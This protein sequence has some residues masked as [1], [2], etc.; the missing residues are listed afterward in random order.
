MTG[1]SSNFRCQA[2]RRWTASAIV[3]A[4]AVPLT[5]AMAP[6]RA[7][8]GGASSRAP[9]AVL[10]PPVPVKIVP[11]KWHPVPKPPA[12]HR[13]AVHWPG[14][15]TAVVTAPGTARVAASARLSNAALASP[16]PGAVRAGRLPVWLGAVAGRSAQVSV[17]L[18][19]IPAARA[20]GINGLIFTLADVGA[21]EGSRVRVSLDY[22]RFAYAYLGGWASML[23]LVEMPAC[24]LTTP[25]RPACRKQV[26]LRSGNDVQTRHLGGIVTLPGG[27]ANV[28]LAATGTFSSSSGDY[29]AT[30]LGSSGNW[31]EGGPSGAFTYSYPI[32]VPPAPGNL[33]PTVDLSYSSQAVDGLTSATNNQAS[34]IGDG[35]DYSPGFIQRNYAP[36]RQTGGPSTDDLCYSSSNVTTMS[37][38]GSS[39]TLVW[40]GSPGQWKAEAD[41][42]A[43]VTYMSSGT[44]NGTT[45]GD[46]WVVKEPD[47]TT[48]YF[49]RQLPGFAAGDVSADA[50]WTVPVYG[51]GGG[52]ARTDLTTSQCAWRWMLDY[53]V[54]PHGN[55]MAYL[56]RTETNW[57]GGDNATT[58]NVSYTQ[59]GSLFE[60]WYGLT[61]SANIYG[62]TDPSGLATNMV[63][64]GSAEVAFTSKTDRTDIDSSLACASG[65]AS[66]QSAPTFWAKYRLAQIDTWANNG[67]GSG[68]TMKHVDSWALA[69][70]YET[71][72]GTSM[73]NE[74]LWLSSITP[75][76]EDLTAGATITASLPPVSF[77][78]TKTAL[79]NLALNQSQSA[80]GFDVIGRD[81]ISLVTTMTG[82]QI[83]VTYANPTGGCVSGTLPKLDSNTLSCYPVLFGTQTQASTPYWFN[84][85]AVSSVTQS[86]VTGGA[87][88]ITTS[89][90]YGPAAWHYDDDAITK[91]SYRTWDQFR[92]F[93]SVTTKT[94]TAPDPVTKVTDY[95]FQ[96]MDGDHLTGGTT[97]S[98]TLTSVAD[99]GAIT[100]TDKNQWAGTLFEQ[101]I[102]N[103]DGGP[104]VTD[105]ATTPWSSPNPTADLAQTGLPDLK[106][107]L[108]GI[109][110]TQT[111]TT[112]AADGT[113]E[114]DVFYGHDSIG[115]IVSESDVPDV[116]NPA[117]DTCTSTSYDAATS[118][119]TTLPSEVLVVPGPRTGS[120]LACPT[121]VPSSASGLIS[122]TQSYY[123][124]STT[125]GA[126]PSA[127]DLSMVK[128]AT[129][130]SGTAPQYTV[131]YTASHDGYGRVTKSASA[132]GKNTTINY[133][134]A[135]GSEPSTV[136][137][138]DPMGLV[139]TTTNDSLRNL[140]IAVQDPAGLVTTRNYDALGRLTEVWT[141]GHTTAMTPEYSFSYD[142]LDSTTK[143][144]I[145]TTKT[146]GPSGV[147]LPSE[148]F[149]DSLGRARETQTETADQQ[150]SDITETTYNSDGWPA[151]TY[152]PYDSGS[153]PSNQLVS[154]IPNNVPS[155]T[156][157]A[158]DGAGRVTSKIARAMGTETWHTDYAYGGD[159]VSVT[160]D[161]GA[162]PAA[163][164]TA[165]TTYTDGRGLTT[166]IYQYHFT[167]APAAPPKNG[168]A[169]KPG[170]TGWDFTS[171]AYDP[172]EQLTG[173]T[174]PAGSQW[175]NGYDLAGDQTS[176][177]SPD[178]GTTTSS[179][180]ALGNQL[181]ATN[182][183]GQTVS[184][185]YDADNRRTAE[186]AT[187]SQVPGN[188]I[189]SW[190]WD[191][192]KPGL[193]TSQSSYV[194]GFS[195]T[196]GYTQTVGNYNGFGLPTITQTSIPSGP[197]AGKYLVGY[198]YFTD[199]GQL[200]Q[201]QY[202]SDGGLPSENVGYSYDDAGHPEAVA[203]ISSYVASL[204]YTELGQPDQYQL[205]SSPNLDL[206]DSWYQQTGNLKEAQ[207]TAGT[208]T[209]DNVSYKYDA[210]GNIL[211]E[212]DSPANGPAQVQCFTYN[213]LAQLQTA[214]SQ[215]A[216]SCPAAPSQ[217][218]ESTAAAPYW[219]QYSYDTEG[220]LT[221]VTQTPATGN[222]TT[223]T[224]AFGPSSQPGGT[225]P[226]GPHQIG[227]QSV[228]APGVAQPA[229]T[230]YGWDASGRL[231]SVASPSGTEQ[232]AWGAQSGQPVQNPFQLTGITQ[233]NDSTSYVYDAS[234]NLLQQTDNGTTTLYLP[235]EQITSTNGTLSGV[236][237]YSLGGM[238]IAARATFVNS[239]GVTTSGVQ[240]LIGDQ[241][242]T[243]T[244]AID[245]QTLAVTR[246]YYDPY[247]NPVGAGPANPWPGNRGFAGGTADTLTNLTNL[248]AR[249]YDP[250]T[251]SF[252]SPD[253]VLSPY[254]PQDLNPYAY[255]YDNPATNSDPTGLVCAPSASSNANCSNQTV[256][257][258]NGST[259]TTSSSDAGGPT[260][261]VTPSG[262]AG[263]VVLPP[264]ARVL[265]ARF[266]K[267]NPNA[268]WGAGASGVM[269]QLWAFCGSNVSL[270]G[271]GLS[272]RIMAAYM[273]TGILLPNGQSAPP[274]FRLDMLSCGGLS[275]TGHS[276][277]LTAS[278]RMT[279][280]NKL[281][282]GEMIEALK[283]GSD[284]TRAMVIAAVL[285]HFDKNRY[286]VVVSVGAKRRTRAVIATTSNHLFWD[287]TTK[288]WT[289]AAHLRKG[290]RLSSPDG[291]RV[292]VAGGHL[293]R[294]R[295]G[296]LWD[297]NVPGDHD[298]YVG[299]A[300]T[301]VLVHNAPPPGCG[302]ISSPDAPMTSSTTLK[303]K[304]GPKNQWRVDIENPNPGVGEAGLHFQMGGRG[305]TR[306]FYNWETEQWISEDDGSVLPARIAN[307]IPNGVVS[308]ALQYF[309]LDTPGAISGAPVEG[310]EEP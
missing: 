38:G 7:T 24:A 189:A 251:G 88:T 150:F 100:V 224:D 82:G 291:T 198:S 174:D 114:S 201:L 304:L 250:G 18:L 71:N 186:Y 5:S 167:P 23:N 297:L 33:T 264:Q 216:T 239:A 262:P 162:S 256:Q 292:S 226:A 209:V 139:T 62:A 49:G 99:N 81:R 77:T 170:A 120:P 78:W 121:A 221:A 44:T 193:L 129:S 223:I 175:S 241:Q 225:G 307:Y 144:T 58:G 204:S 196:G 30:P 13:P 115:R 278:G 148:T 131:E 263:S 76:G 153:V 4:L 255:A 65:C 83:G 128:K 155:E 188:E 246:R 14:A 90:T 295:S 136:T 268:Y 22:A 140:P 187:A 56:Y 59:G 8:N 63:P 64:A 97:E 70:T 157:Y 230:N 16:A 161:A 75:T 171:Y 212:A 111:F 299:A 305:S 190:T 9:A 233:G 116:S 113:R 290:D 298:F 133:S 84:K 253:P 79:Q 147:A 45:P 197:L 173:I 48:Y 27:G 54:D 310:E 55:A 57:Y 303:G 92:G 53:V 154:T 3:L 109:A 118:A 35:W 36:C 165:T 89:Y 236:R 98:S 270:C 192:L 151:Y 2:W 107:W 106:A 203:G 124:G 74:P 178:S 39:T 228:Q 244:L 68:G 213:Y 215:S 271:T 217:T 181:S 103:G 19:P 269:N 50:A 112:T 130:Y 280:I 293:S 163:T 254:Q 289:M 240:Y 260:F 211:S 137:S 252:T 61:D 66:P 101:I 296:W 80:S 308:R 166:G 274:A 242:G 15:G 285:V 26:A 286:D 146:L 309:G 301:A 141:P 145:V 60:I 243:D 194:G 138:T 142:V 279:A 258:N 67:G 185:V 52:C 160:P 266:L 288:H 176:A 172:A 257:Q 248:G 275:F 159:Y 294:S 108:T 247:G 234:G 261:T 10:P 29:S 182:Q 37:L 119:I 110:Q 123:D 169:T 273:G 259:T 272:M 184:W 282:P 222:A 276:K 104:V 227:T 235:G 229:V 277:V 218:A 202:G 232:L 249:E 1:K 17:R 95:Y 117:E 283:I 105:A 210:A 207:V 237:Y 69:S 199:T 34:W 21:G 302:I 168:T 306:Y 32:Q 127:G 12:W 214:W 149:Y 42:G 126:G 206:T 46:Y 287:Q 208:A 132:N 152:S 86:D 96:G 265:F 31:A 195:A 205:D 200:Q 72:L 94:G 102:Y 183:A 11:S 43:T 122:D 191:T 281:K 219:D 73:T 87:P 134:P 91:P 158:Y 41:N 25:D 125:L 245:S 85:Y 164:A 51:S 40:T 284:R 28:V 156:S 300:S 179:Y 6:P 177:T 47:G 180:D 267:A 238:T 220:N 143:Q 231:T 20:A 93:A 135:T